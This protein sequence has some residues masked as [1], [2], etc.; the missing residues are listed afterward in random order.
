[1]L[2]GYSETAE[3]I[4]SQSGSASDSSYASSIDSYANS[5]GK[6][7]IF[8]FTH[9]QTE[10]NKT[11]INGYLA[12]TDATLTTHLSNI[13]TLQL[14]QGYSGEIGEVIFF[15]KAIRNDE[16]RDIEKYLTKK[17]KVADSISLSLTGN[18]TELEGCDGGQISGSGCLQTCSVSETGIST[19]STVEAGSG[20]LTCNDTNFTGSINYTCTNGVFAT[21]DSCSCDTGYELSGTECVIGLEDACSGGIKTTFGTNVLFAFKSSGTFTC[22][23]EITGA[24]ILVVA[25]GGGGAKTGGGGGGAG[26]VVYNSNFTLGNTSYNITAG[27]GGAPSNHYTINGDN[28][29]D[30]EF[31]TDIIAIGGGGGGNGNVSSHSGSNGGSG[32]GLGIYGYQGGAVPGSSMA[33][34]GGTSYGNAGGEVDAYGR[35]SGGGGAGSIGE[36]PHTKNGSG[37]NTIPGNG[38]AGIDFSATF[39]TTYGESGWFAGGGGGGT[40]DPGVTSDGGQ[41]GGGDLDSAGTANTGGGGGGGL[42]N[43]GAGGSGIVLILY[44]TQ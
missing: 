1:L 18:N 42:S 11:Y 27:S 23:R 20:S 24:K 22:T 40:D 31:S 7:R 13:S 41:G 3:V 12:K 35:G 33:G 28:G 44:D 17:F 21:E 5:N 43:P 37:Y 38:G 30:S 2:L 6:A 39:G 32:G 4:H 10:G 19:P 15:T 36:S 34:T 16:R 8:T 25:G 14:G 9:S 29:E 26:G